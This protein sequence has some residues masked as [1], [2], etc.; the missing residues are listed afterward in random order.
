MW[1]NCGGMQEKM[2]ASKRKPLVTVVV[3]TYNRPEMVHHAIQSVLAQTYEPLE[4]IIVEDGSD[5][6]L[7]AWL[8]EKCFTQIRY[9]R[10]EKNQGLAAARN[11]AI[12]MATA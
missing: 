3:T 2:N 6:G 7:E 1:T 12:E 8:Q 5:S 4:I 9:I 10:H 11:T